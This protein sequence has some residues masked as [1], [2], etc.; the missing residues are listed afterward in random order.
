M[1]AYLANVETDAPSPTAA[2]AANA[3]LTVDA[4]ANA[5]ASSGYSL[6]PPRTLGVRRANTARSGDTVN[7][8]GN[9][10]GPLPVAVGTSHAAGTRSFRSGKAG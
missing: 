5:S 1:G 4:I 10:S 9:N 8:R 3:H 7:D 2:P 6:H